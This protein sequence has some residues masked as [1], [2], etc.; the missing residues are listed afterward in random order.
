MFLLSLV[1]FSTVGCL[2]SGG[3]GGSSAGLA[4]LIPGHKDAELR[5]RAEADSFPTADQALGTSSGGTLGSGVGNRG[6]DGS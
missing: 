6:R 3:P 4:D 2:S 5:R 1:L